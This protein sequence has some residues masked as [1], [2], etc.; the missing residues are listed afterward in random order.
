MDPPKK[1]LIYSLLPQQLLLSPILKTYRTNYTE[2]GI[3]FRVVI[4]REAFSFRG[5]LF[6]DVLN[7]AKI[8]KITSRENKLQ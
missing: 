8:A 2:R 6:S 4:Y 5:S 3:S 1:E 7:I